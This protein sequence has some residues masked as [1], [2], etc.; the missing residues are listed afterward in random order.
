MSAEKLPSLSPRSNGLV[1]RQY[2]ASCAD[3]AGSTIE[4][5]IACYNYL[6]NLGDTRCGVPPNSRSVSFCVANTAQ[7]FGEARGPPAA[8]SW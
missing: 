7:I 3:S 1:A 5:A 6:N 4:D 2:T 8:G